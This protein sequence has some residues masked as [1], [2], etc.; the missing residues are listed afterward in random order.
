MRRMTE[1]LLKGYLLI[2]ALIVI[3]AMTAGMETINAADHWSGAR[4]ADAPALTIAGVPPKTTDKQ[5]FTAT[6]TFT[7]RVLGFSRNDVTAT[8]AVLSDFKGGGKNYQIKVTPNGKG[9]VQITVTAHTVAD[10]AGNT[11]PISDVSAT[12]SVPL[13]KRSASPSAPAGRQEQTEKLVDSVENRRKETQRA[14]QSDLDTATKTRQEAAKGARGEFPDLPV[15][16]TRITKE[17]EGWVF[18]QRRTLQPQQKE[19]Q[20]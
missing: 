7:E 4:D 19:I 13:T 6:F 3:S 18:E 2:A 11:G 14:T 17:D 16:P 10:A 15:E 20:P 5:P 12:A 9:N 1:R 8:N